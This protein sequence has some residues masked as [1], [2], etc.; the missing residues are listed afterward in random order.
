MSAQG[1][2]SS[3]SSMLFVEWWLLTRFAVLGGLLILSCAAFWFV[4]GRHRWIR[5]AVG[6]LGSPIFILAS[7]SLALQ[8]MAVGCLSYSSPVY[9]PDC[10]HAARV[11]TDDEG[12]TGG[13][14]HVE[15]FWNYGFSSQEVY[16]GGFQSVSVADLVWDSNSTLEVRHDSPMYMCEGSQKVRVKCVQRNPSS[17]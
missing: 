11:R 8:L 4:R 7:L 12:A 14:S 5:I 3:I 2:D 13:N 10:L 15:L 17:R 6:I 1:R 9:S 16:S